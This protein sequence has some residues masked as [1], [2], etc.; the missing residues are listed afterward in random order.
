MEMMIPIMDCPRIARHTA[1]NAIPGIDITI[2][3]RRIISSDIQ[4]RLTAAIA[5]I[6]EP[7][8]KAKITDDKPITSE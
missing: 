1:A 2:S 3:I 8:T 4:V 6:I 5:P 7:I